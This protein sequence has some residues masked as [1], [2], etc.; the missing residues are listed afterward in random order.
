M[1]ATVAAGAPHESASPVENACPK[2][3]K[4][5]REGE[6]ACARCGLLVA[7]WATFASSEPPSVT[8]LDE[9]WSEL[10]A[11]WDDPVAHDRLIDL[12]VTIGALPS[13]ARRY[14]EARDADPAD[15]I[16]VKR[17]GQIAVYLETALRAQAHADR[18]PASARALWLLGYLVAAAVLVA[19]VWVF[20]LAFRHSG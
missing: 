18:S 2:C 9:R 14:R 11:R 3:K 17:L 5:C 8:E 19:S 4:P 7:R 12:G 6:A 13:L 16:A 15:E 20:F 10:R 1:S